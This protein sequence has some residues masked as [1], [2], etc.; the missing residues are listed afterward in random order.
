VQLRPP[1]VDGIIKVT[2]DKPI[3][4]RLSVSPEAPRPLEGNLAAF[5]EFVMV[6]CSTKD[7]PVK[8]A[9]SLRPAPSVCDAQ[10]L[11]KLSLYA[12]DETN[13][14]NRLD[15]QSFDSKVRGVSGE[16]TEARC[17]ALVGPA[18]LLLESPVGKQAEGSGR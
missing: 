16:D 14:W 2:A 6:E 17:Y 18:N 11:D 10:N 5:T 3:G 9:I 12:F 4:A 1:G 7:V 13:G 15:T 8:V